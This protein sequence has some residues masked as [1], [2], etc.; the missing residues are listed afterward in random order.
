LS[1][2]IY[3]DLNY[4]LECY[5]KFINNEISEEEY[6][7]FKYQYPKAVAVNTKKQKK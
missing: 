5:Q 3:E 6:R 2:D 7:N 1:S 4:W